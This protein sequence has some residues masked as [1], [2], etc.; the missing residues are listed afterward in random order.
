M[1]VVPIRPRTMSLA[2]P[3]LLVPE[4]SSTTSS[5]NKKNFLSVQFIYFYELSALFDLLSNRPGLTNFDICEAFSYDPTC[6]SLAMGQVTDEANRSLDPAR[7]G[8]LMDS[9][10]LHLW[11]CC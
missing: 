10:A 3:G 9:R 4:E 1:N 7:I 5:L 6:I 2:A 8:W 11:L